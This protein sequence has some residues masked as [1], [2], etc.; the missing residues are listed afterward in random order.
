MRQVIIRLIGNKHLALSLRQLDGLCMM[1]KQGTKR[2]RRMACSIL[3]P[4]S[5]WK[6]RRCVQP[7][8]RRPQE[9]QR[10]RTQATHRPAG[11]G[12]YQTCGQAS[13]R[14]GP[15]RSRSSSPTPRLY[16]ATGPMGTASVHQTCALVA[17]ARALVL[18]HACPCMRPPARSAQGRTYPRERCGC[19]GTPARP[20]ILVLTRPLKP[21]RHL[22]GAAP[23]GPSSP[24]PPPLLL[25]C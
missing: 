18:A 2:R 3:A 7:R 23:A 15:P 6:V 14:L 16:P 11:L 13:C 8:R 20:D 5:A 10:H 1:T 12:P 22:P 9:M 19:A 21:C 4:C 24:A 17:C 25:Y